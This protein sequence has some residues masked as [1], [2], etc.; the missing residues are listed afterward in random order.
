M[1]KLQKFGI[2]TMALVGAL[3]SV[4]PAFAAGETMEAGDLGALVVTTIGNI[5]SNGYVILGALAVIVGA[6]ILWRF[7]V[8]KATK[9]IK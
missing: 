1:S 8:K 9:H 4:S 2:G 7:G 3:V 5:S 6:M